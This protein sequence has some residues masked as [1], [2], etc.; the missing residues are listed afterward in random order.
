MNMQ[1]NRMHYSAILWILAAILI[2]SGCSPA[3]PTIPP[4]PTNPG[5]IPETGPTEEETST[6]LPTEPEIAPTEA[7]FQVG[8]TVVKFTA[9]LLRGEDNATEIQEDQTVDIQVND[10]IEMIQESRSILNFSDALNVELFRNAIVRVADVIHES[11]GSTEVTLDLTRGHIFVHLN[12]ETTSRMTVETA[13]A[14]IRTLEDGTEFSVCKAPERLTCLR[15]GK[16]SVEV[17][18]QGMKEVI[19]AGEA[20]YILKDKPP[21]PLICA[22]SQIFKDWE[23]QFRDVPTTPALSLMV[24]ALPQEPCGVRILG[25]PLDAVVR[26]RN[27]FTNPSSAWPQQTLKN[28]VT[29]YSGQEYYQVQLLRADNQYLAYVPNKT[30]YDDVN[31]DLQVLTRNAESGDFNYGLVFRG[32]ENQYYAFTISPVTKTWHVLKSSPDG[33]KTLQEGSQESI[34]GLDAEDTLRLTSRGQIFTFYINGWL[35]YQFSD[36]DYAKGEVGLFVQTLD[37]PEAL[38]HFDSLTIWNTRSTVLYPT[39]L[40]REL[41]FNEK[42]DDGDGLVD[43]DDPYC[44]TPDESSSETLEPP[45]GATEPPVTEP[46]VT[47]PPVTEPPVTEPPVTEPPVTEPPAGATPPPVVP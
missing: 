18:G 41:C 9:K 26:Y 8:L 15:V 32:S 16:G 4:V 11:G 21:S 35:A 7:P 14:T 20:R 12:E 39:P 33:L 37:S 42:D 17:I 31:V 6:P 25:L 2:V 3:A 24:A 5:I 22:P 13:D 36:P 40:P 29:G 44:N 47:E 30:V 28:L 27:D 23:V 10:Q 46:P 1:R 45:I 19:N 34:Q 43:K 38:V